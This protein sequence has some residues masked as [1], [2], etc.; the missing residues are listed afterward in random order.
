[1]LRVGAAK[2]VALLLGFVLGACG[3]N[4]KTLKALPA[5]SQEQ[6]D[7]GLGE[8]R[9]SLESTVLENYDQLTYGNIEAFVDGVARD[10]KLQIIGVTPDDLLVGKTPKGLDAYRRLYKERN[11]RILSKN[12]DVQLSLDGSVGWVYDEA[13]Y[14]VDFEGREASIPIRSTAVYV[15]D[16]DRWVLAAEHLSHGVPA[17]DIVVLAA[18]E[19]IAGPPSMKTDYGGP[20]ERAAPLL[21]LAGTLINVGGADALASDNGNTLVLLP[22][23]EEEFHNVVSPALAR[24]FGRESTVALKEFRIEVAESKRVAWMVGALALRTQH[25]GDF[26]SIPLRASFVFE[27]EAQKDWGIV[28]AHISVPLKEEQLSERAFG[29]D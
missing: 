27:R 7:L 8:L 24:L 20:R 21:G 6:A 14:R 16:V 12:L 18:Q 5:A 10:R 3:G 15:R 11:L 23:P 2:R 19:R 1:M 28:Q 9:K 4:S 17:S 26:L 13:S 25:N 29:S 22:G